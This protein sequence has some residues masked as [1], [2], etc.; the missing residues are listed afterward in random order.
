MIIVLYLIFAILF[1]VASLFA[2]FFVYKIGATVN[3]Y[4]KQGITIMPDAN[5]H[6]I[7]NAK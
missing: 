1:I 2:Y 4:K 5:K 7:G 3:F 6:L